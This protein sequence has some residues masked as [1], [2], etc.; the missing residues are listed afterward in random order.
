MDS[1]AIRVDGSTVAVTPPTPIFFRNV[2]LSDFIFIVQLDCGM[3]LVLF[4]GVKL[5]PAGVFSE[6]LLSFGD[7]QCAICRLTCVVSSCFYRR[8]R[9][10]KRQEKREGVY[11][12]FLSCL[13]IQ[14]LSCIFSLGFPSSIPSAVKKNNTFHNA[15]FSRRSNF[16]NHSLPFQKESAMK[17]LLVGGFLGSGKTTCILNAARVLTRQGKKV[18]IITNDQGDQQVDSAYV[19][20]MDIPVR[21]VPNGCFCCNYQQLDDHIEELNKDSPDIIFAESVGTCTDLIATI[22]RPMSRFKP[23]VEIVISIFADASLVSSIIE[24]RSSFSEESVRYIYKKQLEEAD[25]LV[26]NKIDLIGAEQMNSLGQIIRSEYPGKT[27]LHQNSL[28]EC[29]VARWME[30]ICAFTEAGQR[31]PLDIDYEIYGAGEAH[32][33]WLDK[34][35]TIIAQ[36]QNARFLAGQ[37]INAIVHQ[38]QSHHLAIGHLKFFIDSNGTKEKIS[39]TSTSRASDIRFAD[40]GADEATMLINARVETDPSILEKFVERSLIQVQERYGCKIVD[41]K[42]SVFK[43]GF[44]RPTHRILT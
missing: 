40:V 26:L 1:A 24:G 3:N 13:T 18:A 21:E 14:K 41:G 6:K 39:I 11:K 25:I 5:S 7:K 36:E 43:P 19:K 37:V 44:P 31:K 29:D 20:S 17:L 34:T 15:L 4:F 28:N 16:R 10:D 30:N 38:I 32:L 22:A 12:D 33:A 8:G 27:I 42:W 23:E 9:G 35:L 2:R